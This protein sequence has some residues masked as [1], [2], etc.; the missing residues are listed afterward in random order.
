[1]E[2]MY[3]RLLMFLTTKEF[4]SKV[5]LRLALK[6]PFRAFVHLIT[7]TMDIHAICSF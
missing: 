2:K 3:K 4:V 1:M 5:Q 7:K 6:V